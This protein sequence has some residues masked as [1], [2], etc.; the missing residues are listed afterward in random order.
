[1]SFLCDLYVTHGYD[2][3]IVAV[4]FLHD[5]MVKR[6]MCILKPNREQRATGHRVLQNVNRVDPFARRVL[7][8][9]AMFLWKVEG[10]ADSGGGNRARNISYNVF[11]L[12]LF[13]PA[14]ARFFFIFS[15]AFFPLAVAE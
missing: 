8:L 1:M 2:S 10:I 14:N 11:Y 9:L 15:V 13:S 7:E 4:L 3:V 5:K 12:L 6:A